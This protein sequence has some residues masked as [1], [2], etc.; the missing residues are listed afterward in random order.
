MNGKKIQYV[1][2][3]TLLDFLTFLDFTAVWLNSRQ[4]TEQDNMEENR[5][6]VKDQLEPNNKKKD[7]IYT[8]KQFQEGTMWSTSKAE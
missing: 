8:P 2:D 1:T 6:P 3:M 4:K 7:N 5:M